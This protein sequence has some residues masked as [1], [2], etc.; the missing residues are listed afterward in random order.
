ML[1]KKRLL[2]FAV[3]FL[4]PL[5]LAFVCAEGILV[6]QNTLKT[7]G[8]WTHTKLNLERPAI[9]EDEFFR[10]PA[11]LHRSRLHLASWWGFNEVLYKEALN[12]TEVAFDFKLDPG[13]YI[14]FI[15][16]K[17][18]NGFC[19]IRL[20]RSPRFPSLFFA[21][22]PAG[23]FITTKPIKSLNLGESWN[24]FSLVSSGEEMNFTVNDERRDLDEIFEPGKQIGFRSGLN[25]VQLD[26]VVIRGATG[27]VLVKE[28]FTNSRGFPLYLS[29]SF[30]LAFGFT[31]IIKKAFEN[32]GDLA[33]AGIHLSLVFGALALFSLDYFI[34]SARQ[35]DKEEAKSFHLSKVMEERTEVLKGQTDKALEIGQAEVSSPTAPAPKEFRFMFLGTSQTWGEGAGS[36]RDTWFR[37]TCDMLKEELNPSPV[38][39]VNA[40]ISGATSKD[41]FER[42]NST[43]IKWE[44]THMIVNLSSSREDLGILKEYLPKIALLNSER[45]VKTLWLLEPNS[46]EAQNLSRLRPRYEIVK[47]L[48][49]QMGASVVDMYARMNDPEI[50]DTGI[51]WSDADHMTSYGHAVFAEKLFPKIKEFMESGFYKATQRN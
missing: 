44:P 39:C 51:L 49:K 47:G 26:N 50:I 5:L 45:G 32:L 46:A 8:N 16:N 1:N 13:A 25:E 31:L 29:V 7:N 30:M 42:L 14:T 10:S 41:I 38:K 15:F 27:Q 40:S 36:A 2:L 3:F 21:A 48:V 33:A 34:L 4:L 20:S 28:N 11:T 43:W 24:S 17:D 12:P 18:E 37:L 35:P 22:T 6:R 19:G 23:R 9:G